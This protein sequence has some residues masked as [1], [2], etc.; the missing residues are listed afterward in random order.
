M[1]WLKDI[2]VL[3]FDMDGTLYQDYTFMGRYIKKMMEDG[4]P[5]AEIQETVAL[6]YDILE[7]KKQIKMGLLYD[8]E[9]L[10]FY[11]HQNLEPSVSYS[12]DGKETEMVYSE[13][14]LLSYIGDPWGIV[15]LMAIKKKIGA[16]TVKRAF[17]DVRREMLTEA[18]CISKHTDLLEEI[19]KFSGKRA[20]LMTNSPMP[21]GQDF[22]DF[23]GLDEIFDEIYIDGKKPNGI[24]NLMNELFAEGHQ[25]HEILSI[26]DHPWNDLYPVHKAGGHTCLISQYEHQDTTKWSVLVETVDELA[27]LIKQVNNE[28][29]IADG[30]EEI[31]G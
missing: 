18:Y 31:Y 12:W 29:M 10:V 21:T 7:G 1:H 24:Q 28:A 15:E 14:K 13:E 23:L 6:A 20:I 2:N 3:I 5:E 4:F 30:K 26:G 27:T 25:P 19:K 16:E 8:R 11:S 9:Q 22:V 17:N